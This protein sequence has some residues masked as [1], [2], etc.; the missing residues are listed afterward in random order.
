[1]LRERAGVDDDGLQE[2]L[3]GAGFE[4][5]DAT[6]PIAPAAKPAKKARAA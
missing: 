2:L 4:I 1:L 3:A 5:D 6:G